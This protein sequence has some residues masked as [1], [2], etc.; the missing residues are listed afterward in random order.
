MWKR[1]L[2]RFGWHEWTPWANP[3]PLQD[4]RAQQFRMCNVCK[5]QQ[6]HIF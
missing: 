2:C 4:G 6:R 1:L 3:Q 5:K